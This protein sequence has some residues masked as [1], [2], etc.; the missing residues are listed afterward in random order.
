MKT[1]NLTTTL[2]LSSFLSCAA[3]AEPL[4]TPAFTGPIAANKA[5]FSVDTGILG[6]VYVGGTVSGLA[7]AQNNRTATD[8][9][10]RADLSNAQIFIQNN[11][12]PVQFFVQAGTYSLPSLGYGYLKSSKTDDSF[13]GMVPVA[14]LKLV[15]NDNFNF[16]VGKLPTLIGSEYTFTFQ[17]MNIERG[18]LWA[19][20]NAVAHGVQAN[21]TQGPISTSLSITDGFYSDTYS[22]LSG[23]V[24]Y[25]VD[26]QNTVTL[27][28]GGNFSD[29]AKN[30]LA[31]PLAQNNEEIFNLI[32]TYNKDALTVSPYL[33]YTHVGKNV[34]IGINDDAETIGAALLAKYQYTPTFSVAGRA[35]YIKSTGSSASP[36]LLYGVDSSAYSFTVTPTYQR[37]MFFVR[38]EASYVIAN[39]TTAGAAFGISGNDDTQGRVLLETGIVF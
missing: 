38:A 39:D 28:A 23:L 21:Y 17:N 16:M 31:T 27:I 8:K 33:Q 37:D 30:T 4:V 6:K 9:S 13:Y 7:Y 19:Q 11:S 22:W 18:L 5:P 25:Q 35:E 1:F 15:P 3:F 26:S 32:Y 29:T 36:N 14:Y 2:L 34:D 10:S 12:G 20:E 24:S